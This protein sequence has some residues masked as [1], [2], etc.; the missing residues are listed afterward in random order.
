MLMLPYIR[1]NARLL[2][3]LVESAQS[4]LEGLVIPNYHI[5]HLISNPLS[6]PYILPL[7]YLIIISNIPILVKRDL[8][9]STDFS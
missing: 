3:G 2:A 4:S 6:F 8:T 9:I 5:G 1:Q 7:L